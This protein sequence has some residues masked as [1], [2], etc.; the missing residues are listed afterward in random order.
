MRVAKLFW[1]FNQG[2]AVDISVTPKP[3]YGAD[4]NKAFDILTTP[5]P[6]A[7]RLKDG[8]AGISGV[9]L[10]TPRSAE[11]SAGVVCC[12]VGSLH[13]G[14]AAAQLRD[15]GVITSTTPYEPSYLRFG[16]S[17]L[18]GEDDVDRA[19]AAVRSLG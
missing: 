8:L 4:G 5:E 10:F 11:L 14:M 19:L 18:T 13:P 15:K 3:H 16:T 12:N 2:A 7:T 9:T 17:I 6:L 1:W